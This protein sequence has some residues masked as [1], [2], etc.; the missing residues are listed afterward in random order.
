MAPTNAQTVMPR[1][2]TGQALSLRDNP[3]VLEGQRV[4]FDKEIS[5][6]PVRVEKEAPRGRRSARTR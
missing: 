3:V 4:L 2:P 6:T 1:R 5:L